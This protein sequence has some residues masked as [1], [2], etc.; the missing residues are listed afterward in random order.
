MLNPDGSVTFTPD[1]DFVG[2]ASFSYT[3]A[4]NVAHGEVDLG[5][6]DASQGFEITG[7]VGWTGW[8]VSSLDINGDGL[9]D[10]AIGA[11]IADDGAGRAYVVFGQ[12]GGLGS[13]IDLTNLLAD[14]GFR[15]DQR[16]R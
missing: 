16:R 14:A 10:L 3:A 5:H 2:T 15:D 6:L 8:S 9:S 13:G 4:I 12:Y 11:P 7:P 1:E